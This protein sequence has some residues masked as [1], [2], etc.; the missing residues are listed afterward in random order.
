MDEQYRRWNT[1]VNNVP[2]KHVPLKSMRVREKDVPYITVKWKQAIRK[3]R[4]F[5]NRHK[6][7]QTEESLAEMRKR[8]NAA[9]RI[10]RRAIRKYWREKADLKINLSKFY[11]AFTPFIRNKGKDNIAISLQVDG[12]IEHDQRKVTEV[13]SNYFSTI[14]NNI[15]NIPDLENRSNAIH[16]S[17][18][19]IQQKWSHNS[20]SFREIT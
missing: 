9:T 4:K 1:E 8:R 16:N 11:K 5:A 18:R 12:I 10:G 15:G 7:L 19:N 13:F 3:R 20:F 2:D 14:A 17:V 6:K